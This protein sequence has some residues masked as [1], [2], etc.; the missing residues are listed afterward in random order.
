MNV[1]EMIA[2][3]AERGSGMESQ[4]ECFNSVQANAMLLIHP[5]MSITGCF[6]KVYRM[7]T[8]VESRIAHWDS[9]PPEAARSEQK[10]TRSLSPK[11][12]MA[13]VGTEAPWDTMPPLVRHPI[14][15]D[16]PDECRC[17]RP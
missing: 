13:E 1:L 14:G 10:S 17:C 15:T 6:W 11:T 5:V 8:T 12:R 3:V 16:Q 2:S 7:L 4:W 9:V